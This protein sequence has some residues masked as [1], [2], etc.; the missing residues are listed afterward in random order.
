M[1]CCD[2]CQKLT[3]SPLRPD[4]PVRFERSLASDISSGFIR[5]TYKCVACGSFWRWDA[6]DGWERAFEPS[7]G[8][9]TYQTFE[10]A[11]LQS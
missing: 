11:G 10:V 9:R 2:N 6:V 3:L 4:L 7:K 1:A 8:A 5:P